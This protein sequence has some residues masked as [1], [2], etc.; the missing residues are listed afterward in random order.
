MK[1]PR[2]IG[3]VWLAGG[4]MIRFEAMARSGFVLIMAIVTCSLEHLWT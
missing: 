4:W 2:C 1:R 3:I